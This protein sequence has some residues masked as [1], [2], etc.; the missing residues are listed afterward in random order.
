[1]PELAPNCCI[2]CKKLR[3]ETDVERT[4][5]YIAGGVP[6]GSMTCSR[7]CLEVALRRHEKT[8][9]LDDGV[10]RPTSSHPALVL[11]PKPNK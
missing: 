6:L 2:V 8:G 11:G 3:P 5:T 10:A 7:R 4:W 1:M 9:R